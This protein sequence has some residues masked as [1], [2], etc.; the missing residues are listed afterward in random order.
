MQAFPLNRLCA[1][2]IESE[3]RLPCVRG[4]EKCSTTPAVRTYTGEPR[5]VLNRRGENLTQG[6]REVR[7]NPSLRPCAE[8]VRFARI[9]KYK[10]YIITFSLVL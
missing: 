9:N 3:S 10:L 4:A 6:R 8:E 1:A 5:F 2:A 7:C